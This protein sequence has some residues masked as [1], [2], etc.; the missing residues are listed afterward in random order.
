MPGQLVGVYLRISEPELRALGDGPDALSRLDLASA[1]GEGRALDLGSRWDE[2]GCLLDGGIA[3]PS[4]GPTVGDEPLPSPETS[5]AWA[6]VSPARVSTL[7]EE[8]SRISRSRFLELYRVDDAETADSLPEERSQT[9]DGARH[10][11]KRFVQ[12]RA[13]Y[14]DAARRGEAM[15]VRIGERAWPRAR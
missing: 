8:L 9:E 11:F 6:L 7:A 4:T 15:L 1:I 3:R 14:A 2:L 12:L 10:L 13:H 5:V